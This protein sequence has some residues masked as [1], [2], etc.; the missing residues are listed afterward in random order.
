MVLKRFREEVK[1]IEQS[2]LS[3]SLFCALFLAIA[4]ARTS[5]ELFLVDGDA[6]PEAYFHYT[7][8]YMAVFLAVA[9]ILSVISG[10]RVGRTSKAVLFAFLIILLPPIIDFLLSWA[11]VGHPAL[12]MFKIAYPRG[13]HQFLLKSFS[14]FLMN[15]EGISPGMLFEILAVVAL[16]FLYVF[17]KTS[18]AFRAFLASFLIYS[19]I[20]LHGFIPAL[21]VE[22][23]SSSPLPK[24]STYAE[25]PQIGSAFSVA[26]RAIMNTPQK[27]ESGLSTVQMYF[28]ISIALSLCAWF[29][30]YDNSK[31]RSFFSGIQLTRLLHY[32]ILAAGGMA[33][34][35]L[36]SI[37]A[38]NMPLP[39]ILMAFLSLSSAF[40]FAASVNDIF[41]KNIDAVSNTKRPIPSGSLSRDELLL[42]SGFALSFSLVASLAASF[43]MFISVL[44]Y[45]CLALIYSVPPIRLRLYPF[46][47]TVI[48][49]CSLAAV[50]AG[51]S[52]IPSASSAAPLSFSKIGFPFSIALFVSIALGANFKDLKD[53]DGDRKDGV[54]NAITLFGKGNE[55]LAAAL[56]LFLAFISFPILVLP[57][58]LLLSAFLGA[59]AAISILKL[60][61]PEPF[62]FL[63]YFVLVLLIIADPGSLAILAPA[64]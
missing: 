55:R 42:I 8:F 11:I 57:D 39:N 45:S 41:D 40:L 63:A 50:I 19:A 2:P 37:P 35:G 49:L 13:D 43:S 54:Q 33:L 59:A 14:S 26:S 7:M 9:V 32:L 36:F 21:T 53:L 6:A 58:F 52:A 48:A 47:S 29:F 31:F 1:R 38:S 28:A 61:N 27:S 16:S 51:A 20:V 64:I 18:S 23:F 25:A 4:L 22:E 24:A 12:S 44:T 46:S 30:L 3:V 15:T 17:S 34:A 5:L 10:E 62:V 60:K 56:F